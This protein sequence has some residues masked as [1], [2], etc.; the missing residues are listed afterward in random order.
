MAQFFKLTTVILLNKP[1]SSNVEKISNHDFLNQF[2]CVDK[3]HK[4]LKE[5]QYEAAIPE[6]EHLCLETDKIDFPLNQG[7]YTRNILSKKD[8]C[9]LSFINWDSDVV[10][11]PHGHPEQAFIYMVKGAIEVNNF[12]V[13]DSESLQYMDTESVSKGSYIFSHGKKDTFDNS[14]H[15][16]KTS[17]KSMTLHFY[18]DDPTKG[19]LFRES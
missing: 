5:K 12:K 18:S 1:L 16:I 15:Q 6:I 4:L 10:T 11:L 7:G 14:I 17:G 13:N 8:G 19:R 9:W 2:A 3:I